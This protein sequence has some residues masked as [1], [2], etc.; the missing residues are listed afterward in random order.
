M[1]RLITIALV[2]GALLG[3]CAGTAAPKVDPAYRL[4]SKGLLVASVTVSGY[5]PGT[6]SHQVVRAASPTETVVTIPINDEANALDWRLGDPAVRDGGYGR[7]AVVELDPGDYE[8][9]RGIIR[10]SAQEAYVSS[11]AFGYRFTIVPGKATYLGNVHVH[12]ELSA[13]RQ[14]R[15]SEV[16]L[17]RRSRDLPILYR[18]YSGVQQAQVIFPEDIRREALLRRSADESPTKLEDLQGLLPRK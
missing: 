7:L 9:R 18:G 14:I 11:H 4:T 1:L 15:S 2:C 3:G 5:N 12:I 16:L 17:D 6:F 10:V 13:D 8:L